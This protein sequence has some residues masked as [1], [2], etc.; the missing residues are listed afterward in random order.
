MDT[1]TTSLD[2]M[3]AQLVGISLS[4][5]P[6][7]ACYIPFAHDYMGA[8]AQLKPEFVLESLKPYLEDPCIPDKSGSKSQIRYECAGPTWH[9]IARYRLR[10]HA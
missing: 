9:H 6:G 2:Y 5:A 10:H 3:R 7:E 1:E 4:T 8:P